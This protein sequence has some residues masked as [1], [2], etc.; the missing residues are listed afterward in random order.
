MLQPEPKDRRLYA[1][2]ANL[3]TGQ[4]ASMF[5]E[6]D[7]L[8]EAFLGQIRCEAA[9]QT[10]IT[11]ERQDDMILTIGDFGDRETPPEGLQRAKCTD[12]KDLGVIETQY[13][14]KRKVEFRFEL[15]AKNSKGAGFVLTRTYNAVLSINPK[16][17]KKS[18]LRRDLDMWRGKPFT[19]DEIRAGKADTDQFIGKFCILNVEH[20]AGNQGGTFAAV[21]AIMPAV[22]ATAPA[23]PTVSPLEAALKA[24]LKNPPADS[25]IEP[26]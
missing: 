1:A 9:K 19:D 10:A 4:P 17:G 6:S 14:A 20:K 15:D 21:T 16:T 11:T 5:I 18:D 3:V 12:I 2:I 8:Y 22:L 26:F 25:E 7:D 24:S 23:A 13:G